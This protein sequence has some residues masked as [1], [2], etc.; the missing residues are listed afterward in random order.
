MEIER[1]LLSS[2]RLIPSVEAIKTR[3]SELGPHL[4]K[5]SKIGFNLFI[6]LNLALSLRTDG[7]AEAGSIPNTNRNPISD[8]FY[9]TPSLSLEN[10]INEESAALAFDEL[11]KFQPEKTYIETHLGQDDIAPMDVSHGAI[12]FSKVKNN[13]DRAEGATDWLLS[14]ITKPG[15]RDQ[16]E[17]K[18][19]EN[20]EEAIIN[21]AGSW[22]D[23]MDK[24][25]IHVKDTRGRGEAVGI[26]LV[27]LNSI[28]KEDHDYLFKEIEGRKVYEDIELM[29]DYLSRIQG[30][31][32][33]FFHSPTYEE[34]FTEENARMAVGLGL[35]SEMLE[36]AGRFDK[37]IL[38]KSMSERGIKAIEDGTKMNEGMAYDPMTSPLWKIGTKEKIKKEIKDFMNSSFMI[39]GKV[40][41][42][43]WGEKNR[44]DPL[45]RIYLWFQGIL[46]TSP[47]ANIDFENALLTAGEVKKA[48]D[49]EKSIRSLQ[50]PDGSFDGFYLTFLPIG[51]SE[52][53]SYD[54]S[55]FIIMEALYT[56]VINRTKSLENIVPLVYS[57]A[58]EVK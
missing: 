36:E 18:I 6:I 10:F 50:K 46:T 28:Y 14:E 26:T 42:Y 12:A 21:Y 58:Q 15:D 31:D 33:N 20:K 17:I 37:A 55:R 23:H 11:T 5:P 30:P 56:K 29:V 34:S 53:N 52:S 45:E 32:G 13:I 8:V 3:L 16:Y 47:A 35:A 1:N 9:E 19:K 24:N 25:G 7:R 38:A 48:I 27:A 39:G 4:R 44:K 2:G 51:M 41:N 54:L 57:N 49:Y 40:R 43:D 22:F